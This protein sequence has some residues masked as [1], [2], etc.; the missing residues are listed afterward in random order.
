MQRMRRV[1]D[2][3][4]VRREDVGE[5]EERSRKLSLGINIKV[6]NIATA[7]ALALLPSDGW[8]T[9][10]SSPTA[11]QPYSP[12]ALQ[13]YEKGIIYPSHH[14]P[15]SLVLETFPSLAIPNYACA[16]ACAL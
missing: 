3:G 2:G 15:S 5:G 12:T 9:T 11:L 16:C 14:H 7:M 13:L 8:T 4:D 10:E 6:I 1:G